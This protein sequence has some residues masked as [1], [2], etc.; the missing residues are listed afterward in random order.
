MHI[1]KTNRTRIGRRGDAK[2]SDARV[3][4]AK[5]SDTRVLGMGEALV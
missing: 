1:T 2:V 3:T 4:N 5:V